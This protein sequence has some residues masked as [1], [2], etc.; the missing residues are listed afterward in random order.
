MMA[1][2]D[3]IKR[4]CD[5][6]NHFGIHDGHIIGGAALW[7]YSGKDYQLKDIDMMLYGLK[8]FLM[9]L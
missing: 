3:R 4:L 5:Y 1:K 2:V 6:I 9:R 7:A 8:I